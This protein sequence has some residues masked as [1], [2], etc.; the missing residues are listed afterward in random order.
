MEGTG[1]GLL[2][3]GIIEF[4]KHNMCPDRPTNHATASRIITESPHIFGVE[5]I[6]DG[7]P[8]RHTTIQLQCPQATDASPK[9]HIRLPSFPVGIG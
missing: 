6:K 3:N 8:G 1:N 5:N 7:D 2:H 4:V 9:P